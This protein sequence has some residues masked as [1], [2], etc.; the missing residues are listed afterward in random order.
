M[1]K[2]VKEKKKFKLP[3]LFWLML[4]LILIFS[5]LTYIIPAGEFA[6]DADGKLLGD[7]FS[8]L[9]EQHP[10]SPW[11]ASLLVLDGIMGSSLITTLVFISGASIAVLL[12]TGA[13]DDFLNWAIYK[14]KDKGTNVLIPIM[15]FLMAY[16]GGFGGSDAL[17]AVVPIGVIFAK[18]LRLDPIVAIGVTTFATLIGF[19]TGPTKLLVP[20]MMMDVPVYSGFGVRFLSLNFFALVGLLY[21]MR[22]VKKI[23]K[24][25]ELSAMGNTD[26]LKEIDESGASDIEETNLTWRTALIMILFFGQYLVIVAYSMLGGQDLYPFMISIYLITAIA[27]G[28]IGQLSFDEIGNNFAKGLGDMAFV[29]FVIGLA[30]VM[31][32]VMTEGKILHTMVYVLTRPLMDMNLGLAAVGITIVI[33]IINPLIPSASSKAA[34]LMPIIKPVTEAIGLTPQVAVQAFQYGDGFTNLMSPALG[35]MVGSTVIADVPFS[36]WAKWVTPITIIM[37]LLSFIWVY[38]LTNIGWVGY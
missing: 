16:L 19:G 25:P 36:K 26:W 30:R 35:W 21:L 12:G 23:E 5:L 37:I 15:F 31:S 33:S 10:V 14:L 3:H 4:G 17:I 13:V 18:K 22:Y 20:Q 7:Q 2:N 8:Y 1:E 32:L 38:V 34:I 27:C 11:K 6:Q 28:I 9:D 29:C 24:N